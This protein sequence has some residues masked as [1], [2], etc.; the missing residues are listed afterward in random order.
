MKM[1]IMSLLCVSGSAYAQMPQERMDAI[2][3]EAKAFKQVC[4]DSKKIKDVKEINVA[5]KTAEAIDKKALTDSMN[6]DL[7]LAL[8]P[9]SANTLDVKIE[10]SSTEKSKVRTTKY[11]LSMVLTDGAKELCKNV[12]AK[13]VTETIK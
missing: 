13:D 11:K 9:A 7:Q 10:A 2:A 4:L 5:N 3:A 8:N 1:L 6:K 12:Y